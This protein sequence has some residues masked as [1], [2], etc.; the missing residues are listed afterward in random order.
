VVGFHVQHKSWD[1]TTTG[2][3]AHTDGQKESA[4]LFAD[5]IE[6][7][8]RLAGALKHFK[9]RHPLILAIPR[10]AVPMGAL[11]A[12]RLGGELDL[13]LVHKIPA[14]GSPEYAIGSVDESGWAYVA[15]H[16]VL[17]GATSQYIEREKVRQLQ[18]LHRRREKYTPGRPP[19]DAAGRIAIVVDDGLA[20]GATMIAALHAVRQRAPSRLVCAVPVAAPESLELVRPHADEVVCLDAPTFF[21]AVGQFYGYFP[22]VEDDEVIAMLRPPGAAQPGP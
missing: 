15:S 5:R 14:P 12:E 11:L 22:Q 18:E 7:A 9:G 13:V 1:C 16:A 17:A 21:M 2:A 6:A 20:T 3:A 8:E 4:M 10:G 19:I